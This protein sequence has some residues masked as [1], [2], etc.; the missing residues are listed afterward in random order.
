MDPTEVL[1]KPLGVLAFIWA[2]EKFAIEE[3]QNKPPA[4]TL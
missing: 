2:S 1:N 3:E 4:L